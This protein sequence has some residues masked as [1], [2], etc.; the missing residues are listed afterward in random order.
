MKFSEF[1]G[2]K[3]SVERLRRQAKEKR[4]F[5]AYIFEGGDG[6]GKK[7]LAY[8]FAQALF[9]EEGGEEPCGVCPACRK[10]ESG[11]HTDIVPVRP[12]GNSIK[13]EQIDAIWPSFYS[14]PFEASKIIVIIEKA[15]TITV[16]QQNKMLKTFEEPGESLIMILLTENTAELLPTIVS[17]AQI[18]RLKPVS[19][20]EIEDFLVSDR[21]AAREDAI[22][23]AAY[24]GGSPGKAVSLLEDGIFKEKRRLSIDCA[25]ALSGAKTTAEFYS[26]IEAY[27]KFSEEGEKEAIKA[28]KA[29][30]ADKKGKIQGELKEEK[31]DKTPRTKKVLDGELLDMV[32]NWFRDLLLMSEGV[33]ENILNRDCADLLAAEARKL[34]KGKIYHIIEE[35]EAAKVEIQRNGTRAYVWKNLFLECAGAAKE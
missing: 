11:N 33:E 3:D 14:K 13:K 20:S 1:I 7:T 23:A 19:R 18:V 25:T 27:T 24:S 29:Q 4:P 17:R 12:D 32:E 31:S 6:V 10:V 9:C 16:A 35:I 21:G 2:N 28:E 15:E 8:T 22:V 5:H 26:K 30:K 34:S